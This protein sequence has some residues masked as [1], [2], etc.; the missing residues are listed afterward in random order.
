ME[1]IRVITALRQPAILAPTDFDEHLM[2]QVTHM[3]KLVK[4][5]ASFI[6]ICEHN[7]VKINMYLY[8]LGGFLITIPVA[9]PPH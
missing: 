8:K 3:T 9:V 7:R 6:V 1:R 2:P 4:I 5:D